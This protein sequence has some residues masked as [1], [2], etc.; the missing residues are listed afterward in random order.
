MQVIDGPATC[1]QNKGQSVGCNHIAYSTNQRASKKVMDNVF[2]QS[3]QLRILISV[4]FE[5]V[6]LVRYGKERCKTN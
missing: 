1:V 2:L 6:N 5:V 3:K 4:S